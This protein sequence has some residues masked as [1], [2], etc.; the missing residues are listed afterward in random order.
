V[1]TNQDPAHK[2]VA[3][4]AL[5]LLLHLEATYGSRTLAGRAVQIILGLFF[6]LSSF[7]RLA[8]AMLSVA[9]CGAGQHNHSYIHKA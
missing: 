2:S 5:Q 6:L 7:L 3:P 1:A 8:A 4:L 9:P